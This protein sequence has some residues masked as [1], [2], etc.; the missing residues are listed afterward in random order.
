MG[1]LADIQAK[2]Q[3]RLQF[4]HKY[5]TR[6]LIPIFF[7]Q[8]A[9]LKIK[10]KQLPPFIRRDMIRKITQRVHQAIFV[11]SIGCT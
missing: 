3:F 2:S 10:F 7:I 11:D 4:H 5:W 1:G 6:N 9:R 8:F